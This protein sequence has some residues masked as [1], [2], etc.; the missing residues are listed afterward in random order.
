M[1]PAIG[2]FTVA[3][4]WIIKKVAMKTV[5]TALQTTMSTAAFVASVAVF[6]IAVSMIVLVYNQYSSFM[7]TYE[8][9]TT[10]N[11]HAIQVVSSSG[12]LSALTDL[13][14]VFIPIVI[15]FL[16]YKLALFFRNIAWK[17]S[18]AVFQI[19]M[20]TQV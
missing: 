15:L 9:I 2:I 20:Q 5:I 11:N 6:G 4:G 10:S 19:G 1:L 14:S 18:K 13:L 8:T 3:A 12:M 16:V 17:L 7:S